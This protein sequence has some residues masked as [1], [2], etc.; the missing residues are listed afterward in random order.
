MSALT[1]STANMISDPT[2]TGYEAY[3]AYAYNN[4]KTIVG[5]HFYLADNDGDDD[6]GTNSNSGDVF[7][8]DNMCKYAGHTNK[9][10]PQFDVVGLDVNVVATP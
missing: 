9:E 4:C 3:E 8:K 1:V 10:R 2:A 6:D 7:V 5:A